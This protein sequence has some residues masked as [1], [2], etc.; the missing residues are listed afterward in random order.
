MDVSLFPPDA[1]FVRMPGFPDSLRDVVPRADGQRGERDPTFYGPDWVREQRRR[2]ILLETDLLY[3]FAVRVAGHTGASLGTYWH[4]GSDHTA[5]ADMLIT[6]VMSRFTADGQP[7]PA[8]AADEVRREREKAFDTLDSIAARQQLDHL[9]GLTERDATLRA[10]AVQAEMERLVNAADRRPVGGLPSKLPPA[11]PAQPPPSVLASTSMPAVG[12]PQAQPRVQVVAPRALDT[13]ESAAAGAHGPRR[14]VDAAGNMVYGIDDKYVMLLRIMLNNPS[15][16]AL[17]AWRMLYEPDAGQRESATE[18]QARYLRDLQT[19]HKLLHSGEGG[20]E[21]VEAPEHT[22]IIFFTAAFGAGVAAA[23]SDVRGLA[24]KAFA[25]DYA[26]MTHD[27][28][29]NLFARLVANHM[30]ANKVR[31]ISRYGGTTLTADMHR[32]EHGKLVHAFKRLRRDAN[33]FLF[34]PQS[35]PRYDEGAAFRTGVAPS[36][37][38]HS[39]GREARRAEERRE[40][41]VMTRTGRYLSDVY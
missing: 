14:T 38:V 24:G 16:A 1:N 20:A 15:E 34:V 13:A 32:D 26:L 7:V 5:A 17:K 29:R 37:G 36:L 28:V 31:S 22:G 9:A 6:N 19:M 8:E 41:D 27:G 30:N 25:T 40:R 4:G 39:S 35:E 10:P 33:G 2:R 21:W 3:Q 23:A 18:A 11:P 12:R